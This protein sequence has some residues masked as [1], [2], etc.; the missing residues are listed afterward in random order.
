[1][2]RHIDRKLVKGTVTDPFEGR[3]YPL[4]QKRPL[5]INKFFLTIGLLTS[6]LSCASLDST[7]G[8]ING[9]TYTSPDNSFV[10]ELPFPKE[11]QSYERRHLRIRD[12][13]ASDGTF[14]VTFG[15]AAFNR[16]F[17]RV[18]VVPKDLITKA[19]GMRELADDEIRKATLLAAQRLVEELYQAKTAIISEETFVHDGQTV[20]YTG[21]V[22]RGLK[23]YPGLR[24]S[25]EINVYHG[26]YI[27]VQKNRIVRF[28]AEDVAIP[29]VSGNSYDS[30]FKE[31][32][33]PRMQKVFDSLHLLPQ[34]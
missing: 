13:L 23:S 10:V 20:Q 26:V 1:M 24:T 33:Y 5:S 2:R 30:Q 19:L 25:R 14:N 28:W 12:T 7:K 32:T 3:L 16:A 34:Q 22:Q 21:L 29:Q 6:I 11:T 15:P 8:T 27:Y 4:K 17:Y 31:R 18:M 9:D